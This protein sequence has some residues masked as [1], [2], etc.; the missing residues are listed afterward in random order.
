M[1]KPEQVPDEVMAAFQKAWADK[2]TLSTKECIAAAINAW[3]GMEPHK[4]LSVRDNGEGYDLKT[5]AIIL[6]LT[7]STT[8][9]DNG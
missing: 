3:P 8:E 1:I 5:T 2:S 4:V 6:P 7:Q 9:N